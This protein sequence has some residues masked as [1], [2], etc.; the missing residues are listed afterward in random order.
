MLARHDLRRFAV[1]SQSSSPAATAVLAA[2]LAPAGVASHAAVVR[3]PG[4]EAR[5]PLV[6]AAVA[7]LGDGAGERRQRGAL[8]RRPWSRRPARRALR[9]AACP[10]APRPRREIGRASCRTRV[11]TYEYLSWVAVT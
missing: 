3:P 10:G 4:G 1:L 7:C 2:E 11:L 9:L 8:R 5:R 6:S